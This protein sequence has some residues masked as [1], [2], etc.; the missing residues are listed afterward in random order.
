VAMLHGQ[1]LV[2]VDEVTK[3]PLIQRMFVSTDNVQHSSIF[4]SLHWSSVGT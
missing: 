3:N 4:R 1:Y 2:L